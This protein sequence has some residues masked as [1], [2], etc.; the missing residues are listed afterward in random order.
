MMESPS[1]W[2]YLPSFSGLPALLVSAR[3]TASSYALYVTDLA[4]IWV[5]KLDRRGILL[6]SLQ[7]NTSIDLVDADAEQ[8]AVFLSKIKA[9][10]DPTSSDHHLT[11]LGVDP[12]PKS[13]DDLTLHITCQLP[14]PLSALRWPVHLVK[15]QPAS[16]ASELTLPLIH[17]HY[18]RCHEVDDLMTQLKEKDTVIKKLLDKLNTM[19]TPLELIFNSLSAKHVTTRAAAEEKIKGLA[20]FHEDRW[21]LQRSIETPQDPSSLLQS[22]FGGASGF[23]FETNMDL[24]VSDT[25]NDWWTKL[26]PGIHVADNSE[27]RTSRQELKEQAREDTVRLENAP[28]DVEDFQVQ[29]TPLPRSSQTIFSEKSGRREVEDDPTESDDSDVPDSH[30]TRTQDQPHS[31]IG[32][33]G[34]T[35]L[36]IRG[37]SAS[38]PSQ[39]VHNNDD[40]T[41]SESED[42][43]EKAASPKDTKQTGGKLGVI[44]K[45]K[46]SSR[47]P[48][49]PPVSKRVIDS[50]DETAS[51]FDPGSDHEP[52]APSSPVGKPTAHRKGTLGRIAGKRKV[53]SPQPSRQSTP[54][55]ASDGTVSPRHKGASKIGTIGT[56]GTKS[57]TEPK[58]MHPE[59]SV[60]SDESETAEVKAERKRAELTEK[61]NRQSAAPAKKKRKF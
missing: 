37:Q 25:L 29:A 19:R 57:I 11:S 54:D 2:H 18:V 53:A 12:H 31:R 51:D 20:P 7:E 41:A 58:R 27:T 39:T 46:Q 43:V 22:V 52:P 8:W 40:D 6:R 14:K 38:Q 26:S 28:T 23:S 4:N 44:G 9:V 48:T 30:Q 17:E 49:K 36:S 42:E 24:S 61:L 32:T 45:S 34:T 59:T 33:I 56:I 16:L 1:K 55:T 13:H 35:K 60:N 50:G 47:S 3:F 10:F 5:E 15:C 21:R